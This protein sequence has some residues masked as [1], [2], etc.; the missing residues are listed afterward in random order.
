MPRRHR[1][2]ITYIPGKV[3][4]NA[5]NIKHDKDE[6]FVIRKCVSYLQRHLNRYFMLD[7]ET[8]STICWVLGHEMEQIGAFLLGFFDDNQKAEFEENIIECGTDH[9]E[10]ADVVMN[11]LQ[12]VGIKHLRKFR[13]LI[14]SLL[15]QRIK[16]LKCRGLSNIEKNVSNLKMMFKLIEQEVELCLFLFII[17][18]YEVPESFFDSHLNCTKFSGRKYLCNILN[19]NQNKLNGIFNGV[20]KTACLLEVDKYNIE[21]ADNLLTWFQNPS[22]RI[23]SE[24]FYSPISK[25]NT[26]SINYHFIGDDQIKA[27]LRLLKEKPKTSTHI[28]LY[29][30]PGTGK[31]SFA[32]GLAQE[33]GI[34]AYEIVREEKNTTENRRTAILA[35]L[36]MTNTGK[37]SMILVDEADNILNTQFSWFLRGETQDKGWLNQLLE[38]PEARMIWIA[39]SIYNIEDSVLRRFAFSVHFKP[40]NRRQRTQLWN[41]ILRKNKCKRFYRQSEIEQLAKN[42]KVSAGAIDLAVKKASETP[43]RSKCDF[44]RAV[45]YALDA[46]QTLMHSGEKP[47]VKDKIETNYTLNGLNIHGDI[48][49]VISQ[50]EKFD[51]F[52]RR[53]E[54]DKILNM[55]LLFYGPPGTGKSELARYI[56]ERL[57][58]E[59]ICK[60]VSD[61]HDMYVG[62]TEKNIKYAFAEAEREDAIL[63]I[64]E[65]DSLLFSRERAFHSWEI[66]FTNEF[67]TQMERFRGILICTTNRFQDLDNASIRRFNHKLGFKYLNPDGNIKFYQKL[68]ATEIKKPLDKT[69]EEALK[70]IKGLAPGD[71]RVVRDRYSFYPQKELSHQIMIQALQ[72]EARLKQI[73]Q[74]NKPIGF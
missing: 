35:C 25:K 66:S 37:G 21:L 60:R 46:H 7:S 12:R 50:L 38:E 34:S 30:P 17:H 23:L 68:L 20:L 53:S 28:L 54:R 59:I 29:G 45:I 42:Y 65:A 9:E 41:N 5:I 4:T 61:L 18:A 40:F 8:M 67:L 58:R 63:V 1:K 47:I 43:P 56:A 32:Y 33:L 44:H 6:R 3:I 24:N 10:Y 14:F 13:R 48:N 72:E 51:Q 74:G 2:K 36:N 27:I 11:M 16:R 62:E 19:I 49:V 31:S 57:D 70:N 55:N 73:H 39:N 64:D 52:L 69:T 26:L 71:F 15:E 22:D